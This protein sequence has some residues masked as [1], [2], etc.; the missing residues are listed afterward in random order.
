MLSGIKIGKK[1]KKFKKVHE[2]NSSSSHGSKS[3]SKEKSYENDNQSIADKLRNAIA[4]G[5]TSVLEDRSAS[6]MV[7]RLEL[8]PMEAGN[9][10]DSTAATV[11]VSSKFS[12]I[13]KKEEDMT[14]TELAMNERNMTMS[15]DEQMVRNAI[16]VGKKR[17]KG[18]S[19]DD[20]DEELE[21]MKRL[22]PVDAKEQKAK[23]ARKSTQREEHREVDRYLKQEKV[24]TKCSWWV[25]SKSF[26]KHRL[27]GLGE[28]L[29]LA[30]APPNVSLIP[31]HHFHMVPIQHASSFVECNDDAVWDEVKRFHSALSNMYA[32]KGKGV[33]LLETVL[34]SKGLW[35]TKMDVI[36]VPFSVLQDAPIYFKSSMV[37]QSDEWGTHNKVMATTARKPVKSVLPKKGFPYFYVEWGNLSSSENTGYAQIIEGDSFRHDFGFDTLSSIM[38]L[39]PVRFNRKREFS[40]EEE[41]ENIATFMEGW[42]KFDWTKDL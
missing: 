36:A 35:Q 40:H 11:V 20:S 14:A 29:S 7:G 13:N 15:W 4:T 41:R 21:N 23:A 32:T 28:H 31:G 18:I 2:R 33:I 38:D 34:P 30:M 26:A 39:D 9:P 10:S 22:L 19:G 25:G 37:E 3:V 42:K 17:K 5:K 12:S 24:T 16:R 6:R 27:L 8:I 1:K